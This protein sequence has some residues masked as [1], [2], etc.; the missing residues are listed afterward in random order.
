VNEEDDDGVDD[1]ADEDEDV[2]KKENKMNSEV[3]KA[4]KQEKSSI[5]GKCL[6][7]DVKNHVYSADTS[8]QLSKSGHLVPFQI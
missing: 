1:A 3:D 8:S 5:N 4:M 7:S 2:A 6:T